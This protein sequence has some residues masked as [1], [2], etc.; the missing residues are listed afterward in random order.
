VADRSTRRRED[1]RGPPFLRLPLWFWLAIFDVKFWFV[2]IPAAIVLAIVGWYGADWLG[3]LR[4]AMF[5][6]VA[7]L[8][9]PFPAAAVIFVI[10]KIDSA[11]Y[12]RPLDR[13]ETVS[14][15]QLPAGSRIR[16]GDK[17]HSSVV[18][19]DLPHVTDI[20]G[21]R[22]VGKLTRYDRWRD[23]GQVWSGTLAEDQ[24]VDGLPCR[25]GDVGPDKDSFVFDKDGI[26]QRCTLAAAHELLGLKLPP[27][28]TVM[29]RGNDNKPWRLLL[30][31]NADVDIPALATT[32]P[33]GVTL[34]VANDG[35]LE[36]ISSGHEQ[37]IVV[38]GV[39]LNSKNFHLQGEQ[40][41][42]ELAEP[43]FV[44]GEMRPAGTGVRIDLPTG[45]V[46]VSGP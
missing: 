43:F 15:L 26:V 27:G 13:D 40:V 14:G 36:G 12:W 28:T 23:I 30:P 24:R 29:E 7:L 46:S 9:L 5:G 35:R 1:R 2:T 31:P 34:S 37:T 4:W 8:A 39:P 45:N 32:A 20:R 10:S 22:L 21:M 38:R 41:V 19:I 11:A 42:S 6:A 18:S 17:A 16:F 3:G 44:A 25:A 33:P